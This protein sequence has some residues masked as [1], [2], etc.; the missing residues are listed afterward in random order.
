MLK[1]LTNE[2]V[3]FETVFKF[4]SNSKVITAYAAFRL[5][6]QGVLSRAAPLNGYLSEP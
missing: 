2:P 1:A 6:D 3:T 5:V 4:A